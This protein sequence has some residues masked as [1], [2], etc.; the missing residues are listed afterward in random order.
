MYCRLMPFSGYFSLPLHHPERLPTF[1]GLILGFAAIL[2]GLSS[3]AG[4]SL[5]VLLV[6]V[7]LV[8][9]TLLP[10][11]SLVLAVGVSLTIA[12]LAWFP[13][14]DQTHLRQVAVLAMVVLLSPWFRKELLRREWQW[15]TEKTLASL[16]GNDTAE[17]ADQSIAQSLTTLKEM[18]VADAAIV[19]RQL[20]NVTAEVLFASPTTALPSRLT[21][22]A[23]FMEAIEQ[24]RCLFYPNY[25]AL[26]N[27]A[28]ILRGQGVK[29]LAVM[30]LH[31]LNEMQGAIL[32]LWYRPVRFS[33]SL[34]H[35]LES[36]RSGLGH[37]LRFQDVTLRLEK[38]QA[39][40]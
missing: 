30:P 9:C 21:T 37:L 7:L 13:N 33:E 27:A 19:L 36:L 18:L 32:L 23:L 10:W 11:S 14:L 12:L 1:T 15:A 8:C 40:L 5:W 35:Y 24:N 39:R 17:S 2:L 22:P 4:A 34:Q 20:D 6:P 28:P 38:L 3:I 25:G 26:P 29:S 31:Q 16:I